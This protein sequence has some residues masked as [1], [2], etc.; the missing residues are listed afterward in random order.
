MAYKIAESLVLHGRRKL[1]DRSFLIKFD[2][3]RRFAANTGNGLTAG[4][5]DPNGFF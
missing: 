4:R 5:L 3:F 1:Q 2:T